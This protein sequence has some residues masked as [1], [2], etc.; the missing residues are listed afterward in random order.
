MVPPSFR[1]VSRPSPSLRGYGPSW[2]K[3]R[4]RVLREWGIPLKDWPLYDIDHNPPYDR[5]LEPDHG[6]Y[7]LVPRLRSEHSAKTAASD[8]GFGNPKR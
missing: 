2:R 7:Q 8:G 1:P 6:K 5:D 3:I 4:E